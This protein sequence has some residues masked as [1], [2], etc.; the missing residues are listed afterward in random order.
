M[1]VCRQR[2]ATCTDRSTHVDLR[3]WSFDVKYAYAQFPDYA[4]V[5][6]RSSHSI[7]IVGSPHTILLC[8][9]RYSLFFCSL[10]SAFLGQGVPD[11]NYI[12]SVVLPQSLKNLQAPAPPLTR[13]TAPFTPTR[14]YPGPPKVSADSV[15]TSQTVLAMPLQSAM[16]I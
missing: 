8:M 3:T 13:G 1:Q 15:K 14:G 11:L 4:H 10:S 12:T 7:H 5:Q 9:Q 6:A 2:T 16:G